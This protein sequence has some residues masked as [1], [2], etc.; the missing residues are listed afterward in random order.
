MPSFSPDEVESD[1][2]FSPTYSPLIAVFD[3]KKSWIGDPV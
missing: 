1:E 3:Q 2:E